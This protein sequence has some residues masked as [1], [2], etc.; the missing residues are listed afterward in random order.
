MKSKWLALLLVFGMLLASTGLALAAPGMGGAPPFDPGVGEAENESGEENGEEKGE[1]GDLENGEQGP[2]AFVREMLEKGVHIMGRER[3]MVNGRPFQSDQSELPPVL[4]EGR[5]LVPVRAISNALGAE[6]EW[7]DGKGE[8]GEEG[9]RTV[10]ITRDE[11]VV[12]LYV[13]PNEEEGTKLIFKVC[14]DGGENFTAYELD[15]SAQIFQNRVFVPIRFVAAALGAEVGYCQLT[16]V[17]FV[18]DYAVPGPEGDGDEDAVTQE[19][20]GEGNGENVDA[21]ANGDEENDN[22]EENGGE[23]GNG[24]ESNNGE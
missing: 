2:P 15:V 20:N 1:N 7:C 5:V 13:D 9:E 18:E 3:L 16:R 4:K 11:T 10:T 14:E 19:T 22:G 21:A 23:N 6:V 12:V 24:D 17:A 8:N